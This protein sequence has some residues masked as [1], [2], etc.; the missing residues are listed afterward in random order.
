M[1]QKKSSKAQSANR[2]TWIVIFLILCGSISWSLVM[3]RSGLMYGYGLGFWGP[4]GHDGIWHLAVIES[5]AKGSLE[6]PVFAGEAFKNYHIG[7]DLQVAL[8]HLLTHIPVRFLYFQILPP[9]MA[10]AIGFL[11]YVFVKR[12]KGE[13]S[14]NWSLFYIYFGGSLGW[15]VS[16][17]RDQSLHGESMFWS[18]QAISTLINPPFVL[19]LI[20]LLLGLIFYQ[21]YLASN[22]KSSALATILCF[23]LLL[24]IK[25]YAGV[26]GL[27]ALLLF[28]LYQFFKTRKTAHLW[29]T[30]V[31]FLL[32]FALFLPLNRSSSGL[33]VFKPFWFLETMMGLSDRIGWLRYFEAMLAYKSGGV[34]FKLLP[35]Y[36]IAFMIFLVGN[37]GTRVVGFLYFFSS[38]RNLIQ[39][40]SLI[41]LLIILGGIIVPSLFLQ[42]GT[43]WNTIQFF[44][45]AQFFLAIFSGLFTAS[46]IKGLSGKKALILSFLIIG[47]TIPTSL[48][49]L[50]YHYLTQVPPAT[51][52]KDELEA[53]QFLANEPEGVVLTYPYDPLI[54]DKLEPPIPLYAYISSAYVSAFSQK[55]VFL[56]DEMNLTITGYP[57]DER[58]H[59]VEDWQK[60]HDHAFAYRFLRE[61][62]IS[63]IYWLAGQRAVLGES[64]LGIEEIFAS[65]Q[66]KVYKVK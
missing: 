12:W 23:S 58:R 24:S 41:S 14:A 37:M 28:S 15:L 46:L 49:T 65:D 26:L 43:P 60:S 19:S 61:N 44:Y 31:S 54:K 2:N 33:I 66:I 35:A 36:I 48:A 38:K 4:N 57:W 7:F 45:Y 30:A 21:N 16:L 3:V 42:Q 64:Q 1:M 51:L 13:A 40:E 52:P 34:L 6:M 32:S 17:V 63:Y 29:I 55:P 22:I 39:M 59:M 9:I 50:K 27:I 5:L 56:E 62:N 20:V 11:A 10:I 8:L 47:F 53:L 18:Q 25:A